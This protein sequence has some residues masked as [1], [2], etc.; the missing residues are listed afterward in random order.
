MEEG[1]E[2]WWKS[3]KGDPEAVVVAP[4][5]WHK[6]E[7]HL[8]HSA[9]TVCTAGESSCFLSCSPVLCSSSKDRGHRSRTAVGLTLLYVSQVL[10]IINS[11]PLS[12]IS[13]SPLLRLMSWNH[14]P[15]SWPNARL[16]F[17]PFPCGVS[18]LETCLSSRSC[19]AAKACP[20]CMPPCL[21]TFQHLN[22]LVK[23]QTVW[24]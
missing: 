22:L 1:K 15:E 13:Y 17:L 6:G 2:N 8:P 9:H 14:P 7:P 11:L 18:L 24:V 23:T 12:A 4:G 10:L 5:T 21:A 16:T 3:G 20:L 19:R